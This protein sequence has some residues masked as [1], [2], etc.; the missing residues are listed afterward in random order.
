[1]NIL[2][3]LFLSTEMYGLLGPLGL[4]LIGYYLAEKDKMLGVFWF[5]VDVLFASYYYQLLD[6][7]PAYWWHIIIILFGGIFFC[8]FPLLNLKKR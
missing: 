6:A 7:T 4:V 5:I 2:E 8:I 3:Q 1:M